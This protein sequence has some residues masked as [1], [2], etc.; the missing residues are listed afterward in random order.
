MPWAIRRHST[1]FHPTAGY[2]ITR[3]GRKLQLRLYGHVARIRAEDPAHQILSYREAKGWTMQKG[4]PAYFM[5]VSGGVPSERYGHDGPGVCLGDGQTVA[6][7]KDTAMTG[8]ASAWAMARL[9][10]I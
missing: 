4:G 8:L 2:V 10:P 1:R 3:L 5:V 6:Y 7:L 9:W